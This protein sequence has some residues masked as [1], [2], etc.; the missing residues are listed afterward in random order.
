[1][2]QTG[3]AAG[4]ITMEG[5]LKALYDRGLITEDDALAHAF[6]ARE[7]ARVLGRRQL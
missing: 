6:D 5:F 7:M 2:L 3:V 1:M 4:M